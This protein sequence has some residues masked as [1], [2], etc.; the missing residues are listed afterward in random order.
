MN[1]H[2]NSQKTSHLESSRKSIERVAAMAP[3]YSYAQAD[4]A[5][6]EAAANGELPAG[7][8][9]VIFETGA[10]PGRDQTRIDIPLFVVSSK[11]PYVGAALPKLV[12][13]GDYVR[14]LTVVMGDEKLTTA[15][16]SSMDSVVSLD[17]K[18]ELPAVIT[19]TFISTGVKA[20]IGAVAKKQMAD[21]LGVM[22]KYAADAL[23]TMGQASLNIADTRTWRS[24]PKEFHYLRLPTPADRKLILAAGTQTHPVEIVPGSINVIYVKSTNST[25]KLMVN[26]FALKL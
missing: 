18:N 26:Q 4:F 23:S 19:R 9:Y 16:V 3:D 10:A 2:T 6:S 24:L 17:F 13:Q 22:G 21:K 7:L 1:F 11:V 25:S 14:S 20:T 12:Y 8:T 15:L 5:T